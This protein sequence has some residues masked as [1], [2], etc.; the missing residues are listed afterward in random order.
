MIHWYNDYLVAFSREI[1]KLLPMNRNNDFTH[2]K[3][4]YNDKVSGRVFVAQRRK[5]DPLDRLVMPLYPI[6]G[7]S[8]S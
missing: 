5:P 8:F 2:R 3:L 7:M 6:S 4:P 1:Y